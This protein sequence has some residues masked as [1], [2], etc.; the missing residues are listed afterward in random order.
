[1]RSLLRVTDVKK[2]TQLCGAPGDGVSV[3][4]CEWLLTLCSNTVPC[5]QGQAVQEEEPTWDK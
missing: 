3:S 4:L 1:M 2:G 5:L